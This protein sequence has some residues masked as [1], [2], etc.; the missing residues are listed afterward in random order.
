ML[1]KENTEKF[2]TGNKL[3]ICQV[4]SNFKKSIATLQ[5]IKEQ[6]SHLFLK[7]CF[8]LSECSVYLNLQKA[9]FED[10]NEKKL[11]KHG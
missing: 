8:V 10:T 9:T 2:N 3:T 5:D 6:R 7:I 1:L 11:N 4:I